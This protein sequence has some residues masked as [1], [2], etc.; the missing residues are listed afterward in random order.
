MLLFISVLVVAGC[1]TGESSSETAAADEHKGYWELGGMLDEFVF[2]SDIQ[3]WPPQAGAPAE[4]HVDYG[5]D[6]SA[7][8]PELQVW[9][10]IAKS[11]ED[12][13]GA[14]VPMAVKSKTA[15]S[16]VQTAPITL[17]AGKPY[18]HFKVKR[19]VWEDEI[20]LTDW[21]VDVR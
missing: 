3:P 1:G 17:T 5:F 20:E 21:A 16:V 12:A 14:W 18:I 2:E 13:S 19:D 6:D 8:L 15:E 7:K 4:L 11:E 10:R 9:Y